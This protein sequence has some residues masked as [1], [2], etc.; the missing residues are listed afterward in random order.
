[1]TLMTLTVMV[2]IATSNMAQSYNTKNLDQNITIHAENITISELLK[3]LG[4]KTNVKFS[5]NPKLIKSN[6]RVNI[7]SSNKPASEVLQKIFD[8]K[9]TFKSRGNYVIISPI[10]S[11]SE[12]SAKANE[13][14][15]SGFIL[16]GETSDG[17]AFAS[18]FTSSGN[19]V[20]TDET[21]AFF[22]KLN[23]EDKSTLELRKNGYAP[24][25][26]DTNK[27]QNNQLEL[28]MI[29]EKSLTLQLETDTLKPIEALTSSK[30]NYVET[31]FPLNNNFKVNQENIKDTLKRAATI[32]LYPGFSTY[33]N[34]SGNIQF[35]FA[36]N[37]VGYNRG[38][39]GVELA[40]LS[41]INKE[42][43]GKV[44]LAGLSNYVGGS[45]SGV[46]AAGIFNRV[47]GKVDGL[48]MAGISNNVKGNIH[49]LQM[50]GI[51]NQ[52]EKN[53]N[54]IMMAGIL[55]LVD[56]ISGMQMAGITNIC[57]TI[58]GLQMSGISNHALA[59]DGVQI[60][61]IYNGSSTVDGMQISGL[62]NYAKTVKGSQ[63]GVFNFADSITGLPIGLFSFVKKNGYKKIHVFADEIFPINIGFTTGVKKLHTGLYIGGQSKILK[64]AASLFTLGF[65]IGTSL[66]ISKRVSF[67]VD[68]SSQLIS[69]RKLTTLQSNKYKVYAGLDV[70]LFKN[71]SL[72]GGVTVNGYNLDKTLLN[73]PLFR[74]IRPSYNYSY[75]NENLQTAWRV[76]LGYN[77]GL[78]YS[79]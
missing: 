27:K 17:I 26:Y 22:I 5:Y 66:S 24:L 47:K 4:E 65:N 54:G 7:H 60:A 31:I 37:F 19:S 55:N 48:Q 61:G 51:L 78:R 58:N 29:P 18:I 9:Y 10:K 16:D 40:A 45:V 25:S 75:D 62:V 72:A 71:L 68:L 6:K 41:N 20:V 52:N 43:V 70:S 64:E 21:G 39:A 38:I 3:E 33:G 67:D 76:W 63:L 73:D 23:D 74:N 57:D 12:K 46:Q 49:G 77:I 79:I 34:L 53:L 42:N 11:T 44:Q 56:T 1:M 2:F 8:Q 15:L 35:N 13:I 32:S 36:L 69:K 30:Q 14:Y 50:S 59:I 28:N